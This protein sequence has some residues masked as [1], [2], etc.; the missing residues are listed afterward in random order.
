MITNIEMTYI[1]YVSFILLIIPLNSLITSSVQYFTIV[2][3]SLD[4][5]KMKDSADE[6]DLYDLLN[7]IEY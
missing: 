7:L 6:Y 2:K 5:I 1:V 3:T 4:K